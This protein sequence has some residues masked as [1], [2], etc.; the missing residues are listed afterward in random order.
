MI[1]G[2]SL[3]PIHDDNPTRRFSYVTAALIA[4]NVVI[5]LFEPHLGIGNG[6]SVAQFFYRWGL[7]PREITQG[8]PIALA[9]CGGACF[10]GKNVYVAILTSMFLHAGPVHLIGNMLFL[11]IFGNNVEDVLGRVAYVGFYLVC[12]TLAALS[13]VAVNPSSAFPMVGASG[14]I[15]G[16]LG[17]YLVLFPRARVLT[18]VIV[19]FYIQFIRL[20]AVLVLGFWFVFQ[21]FTGAMQQ[22]GG[23][24]VAWA[25]HV[26]GF[27]AGALLMV[28]YRAL[29]RLP[30][31]RSPEPLP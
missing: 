7:V 25:A 1:P 8:H 11:W 24:G 10:P 2:T 21:L 5:L 14:A 20:P 19:I 15:A 30:P 18:G 9:D 17:A 31:T 23:G 22:I 16:V 26:G 29:T 28:V 3:I 12:G 27:V 6:P 4:L 13:Q